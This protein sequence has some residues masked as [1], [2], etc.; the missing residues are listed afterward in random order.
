[1]LIE[2]IAGYVDL[3]YGASQ[4]APM[5]TGD[6]IWATLS[7]LLLLMG[8]FTI[9]A[10]MSVRRGNFPK[11]MVTLTVLFAA[12]SLIIQGG[13]MYAITTSGS[14][15]N[16]AA[17]LAIVAGVLLLI[18][19]FIS[20]GSSMAVRLTGSIFALVV[21]ILFIARIAGLGGGFA[22]FGGYSLGSYWL[23][24]TRFGLFDVGASFTALGIV[25]FTYLAYVAYLIVALGLLFYAILQKSKIAP[26]AW[27][28]ALVGFLLF[29][30]DMAWGNI[31]SLANANW[32]FV[33]NE[34]AYT[35]TWV[36]ANVLLAIASFIVM[37]ASV[38]GMVYYAGSLGGM[39]MAQPSMAPA[40]PT[41]AATGTF[42]PSCGTQNPPENNFCKKCGAKL[43]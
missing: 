36:I 5:T 8:L 22:N 24:P 38:I 30:I 14:S 23:A 28:I 15:W 4:G 7:T 13:G 35:V 21:S 19:L 39:A 26:I 3:G 1:M 9:I 41:Q 17:A 29:G 10:A 18:T 31:A 37:A 42:C 20:M 12:L 27:V 32:T 2:A 43:G 33:S 6:G 11:R 34:L 25:G 40:L 16:T